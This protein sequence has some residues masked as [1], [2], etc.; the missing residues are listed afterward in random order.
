MNSYEIVKDVEELIADFCE[1]TLMSARDAQEVDRAAAN[2][3][4]RILREAEPLST[5]WH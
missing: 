5:S 2:F 1:Q 3:L 4:T